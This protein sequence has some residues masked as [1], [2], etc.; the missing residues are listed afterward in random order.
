MH[1]MVLNSLKY[2]QCYKFCGCSSGYNFNNDSYGNYH[3]GKNK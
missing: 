1:G 3:Q 2:G